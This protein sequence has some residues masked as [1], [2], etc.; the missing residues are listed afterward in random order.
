MKF[1]PP[2]NWPQLSMGWVRS[3]KSAWRRRMMMALAAPLVGITAACASTVTPTGDVALSGPPSS[4]S[5]SA[6]PS[7]AAPV[8][9]PAAVVTSAP[10]VVRTTQA[11]AAAASMCGAPSN[12]YGYNFCGNGDYIT[13]P[14]AE[15][16]SYFDCIANFSNG[17]GYMVEC[18]DGTYSMSGGISGA[19]SDHGGEN[20]LVYSPS[21]SAVAPVA[22]THAAA[23]PVAHT[24]HAAPPPVHTTQAAPP[25]PST[26]GAPSNPYGYNFCGRGGYITSPGAETCSYFDCIA[27]FSKGRGYMVECNDGTYSMSGGI[28]G[29]CSSH[30]GEDRPVYSG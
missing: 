10:P 21:S 16:C 20:R 27:S 30:G 8:S 9:S 7:A 3:G 24:T 5:A 15:I 28:S 4:A 13:S 22:S 18:N 11:A 1:N 14:A 17:H 2:S 25:Q 6:P 23:P 29:A 26:C 12:P 19:C